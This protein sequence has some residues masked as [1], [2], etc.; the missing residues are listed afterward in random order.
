MRLPGATSQGV[1]LRHYDVEQLLE[2]RSRIDEH[3]PARRL[4]DL[5][6][7]KELVIQLLSVQKLQ[8]DTFRDENTPANQKAQ[9][10]GQV[11][12]ALATLGK[13]QIDIF[14]SE[15]MKRLEATLIETIKSLPTEQQDVF[16]TLYEK[17]LG[18]S[19]E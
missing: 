13:L 5:D 12:N 9:T 1:D 14:S 6:L 15:R 11:A 2:L 16:L 4:K 3:L 18:K 8:A 19:D 7:E 10:A 17:N